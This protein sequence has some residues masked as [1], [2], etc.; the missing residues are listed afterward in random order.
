MLDGLVG[1]FQ[2]EA[3]RLAME[4]YDSGESGILDV[5]EKKRMGPISHL[6]PLANPNDSHF[7]HVV[8]M[9]GQGVDT[10]VIKQEAAYVSSEPWRLGQSPCELFTM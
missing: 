8:E 2:D 1:S 3:N 4:I 10:L 5:L 9:R 7:R 6:R